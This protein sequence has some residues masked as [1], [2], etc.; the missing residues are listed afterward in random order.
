MR[1]QPGI[2][3]ERLRACLQDQYDLSSVTLE[4]L[5]RGLDYHAGV[6]RVVSEQG[7][8]S[9]LKVTSRPLYE[10]RCLVPRYL[11]DQGITAVVAPVPTR[12]GALWTQLEEWTVIVYPFIDGDTSLTG[13][14]NEQWKE[15]GTIFQQIHQV[16]LPPVGFESLHKETFDPTEYARWVRA[17]ETQHLHSRHG[18]S[19]A[20]RALRADWLAHQ[21]TIHTAVTSLEKLAEVLQSRT[22][23]YIICHADLHA[24]NLLRDRHGHVFVIDWDEVMLAPKER[25]FIFVREPQADAFFQGYGQREIDWM[26]L[27]YY[28]WERVVQDVIEDAQNVCFRD[29]WA[30]ETRADVAR[31]FHEYLSEG[32]SNI[33]AAYEASARLAI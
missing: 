17:F 32:G 28:L 12:S 18:G 4:F 31:L 11:N 26:A 21:S 5:P 13:M 33:N 10:P 14:T 19:G 3:E 27:T 16:M 8:A 7:T 20:S 23:P 2:P 6:Y 29:D 24:A 15:V 9:L 25:D 1:E 30:E 22:F